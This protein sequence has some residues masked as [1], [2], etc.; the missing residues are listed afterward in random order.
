MRLIAKIGAWV[1]ARLQLAAPVRHPQLVPALEAQH[2][3]HRV[4]DLG[5]DARELLHDGDAA[6][7]HVGRRI[8]ALV[9][10]DEPSIL[11]TLQKALTLEGYAVDV[12]GGVKIA[13]DKLSKRSYD[14][15]LFD[16]ALPDGAGVD[17]LKRIRTSGVDMP[18]VMMSGHATV[19]AAVRATRLGALDFLEK[20]LSTDRLL[21][22]I[23]NTLRLVRAADG[24]PPPRR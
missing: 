18:V 23:E 11:T 15:A 2:A 19:D 20:P 3:E 4:L 6:E 12:A 21:L 24:S 16:V 13:E 10:D 8:S 22:V 1:D 17:L 5:P 14:L 7:R 9:L